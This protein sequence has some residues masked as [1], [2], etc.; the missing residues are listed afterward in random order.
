LKGRLYGA[1]YAYIGE[2]E[3]C[4]KL[5]KAIKQTGNDNADLKTPA[6]QVIAESDQYD[7][8]LKYPFPGCKKAKY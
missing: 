5:E 3:N 2:F 1:M 7:I 6:L 4:P 8:E